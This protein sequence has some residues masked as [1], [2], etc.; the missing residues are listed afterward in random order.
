MSS[1]TSELGTYLIFSDYEYS[2]FIVILKSKQNLTEVR[3]RMSRNIIVRLNL[4]TN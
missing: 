1:I 2:D 4:K 3:E